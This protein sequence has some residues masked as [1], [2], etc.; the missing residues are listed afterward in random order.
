MR[1]ILKYNVYFSILHKLYMHSSFYCI[2]KCVGVCVIKIWACTNAQ[3]CGTLFL[4]SSI[5]QDSDH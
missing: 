1:N 5:V 2:H 3:Q 4:N